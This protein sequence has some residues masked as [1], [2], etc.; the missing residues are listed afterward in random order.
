ASTCQTPVTSSAREP[1]TKTKRPGPGCRRPGSRSASLTARPVVASGADGLSQARMAV[2]GD[3][4]MVRWRL[5]DDDGNGRGR[6]PSSR[7]GHR[8][9]CGMLLLKSCDLLQT[10]PR[11]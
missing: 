6:G 2:R 11:A 3:G 1:G 4:V 8:Q 7:P 9:L 10:Q 5:Q